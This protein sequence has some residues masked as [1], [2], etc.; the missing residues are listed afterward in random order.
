MKNAPFQVAA[1]NAGVDNSTY[2]FEAPFSGNESLRAM[3]WMEFM[4]DE[5]A[6]LDMNVSRLSITHLQGS[7]NIGQQF[8]DMLISCEYNTNDCNLT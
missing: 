3:H 5:L 6:A 8:S 1:Y 7:A 2:G 4:Y